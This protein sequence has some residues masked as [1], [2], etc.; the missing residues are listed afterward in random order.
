MSAIS[1]KQLRF[2]I[3]EDSSFFRT[4]IGGMLN[5]LGVSQIDAAQNGNQALEACKS[6]HYHVILCDYD[7][8]KGKTGQ[9]LLE[10]LRH[11]KLIDRQT[12][13]I[14][15]T[16]DTSRQAV[17]ASCEVSADDY[18][19]K[20]INATLLNRRVSRLLIQ[21][22][23]FHTAFEAIEN[24][25]L[26][27]AIDA[28]APLALPSSR[29][30]R[31]ANKL[32]GEVLLKADELDQAKAHYLRALEEKESE[33][34][35]LGLAFV[36]QAR[37]N[38]EAAN[39][40]FRAILINNPFCL[41]ALDG[42]AKSYH[43]QKDWRNL[44]RIVAK[45]VS[46][47]PQSILR[48]KNLAN[49]AEQN[50]DIDTAIN[51]LKACVQLGFNSCYGDW[52]DA[53]RLG[54]NTADAPQ[55]LLDIKDKLPAEALDI[56][57]TAT[58]YFDVP[59]ED[60]LRLQFLQGRLQFL[61]R[62]QLHG[63]QAI[64]KAESLYCE[65]ERM[66]VITDVAR[67]KA[68]R[69]L[70]DDDRAKALTDALKEVYKEDQNALEILDEVLDEPVSKANRKLLAEANKRGIELY[71][72]AEFDE[73]ILCFQ[74]AQVMFPRHVGIQLNICQAYIGKHNRGDGGDLDEVIEQQLAT[75]RRQ[76]DPRDPQYKRYKKLC[77]MIKF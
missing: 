3:V 35:R 75:I 26:P 51:A 2:L 67:I 12:L 36:E 66:D 59:N 22:K 56:L 14:M 15:V 37:G 16:A 9:Q 65:R 72:E 55:A 25:Q 49:I 58:D 39:E 47:S 68:I 44:Q 76:L 17:L 53:Y 74:R 6:H 43:L 42:L 62:Q 10:A 7:L 61:S 33:W 18:I 4:A 50:G 73:A 41:A 28:L 24:D 30:Q 63:K 8:G 54:M 64:E 21:K 19:T 77:E 71:N 11:H 31:L 46:A 5:S 27:E 60:L 29:H 69:T 34:A 1:D 70:E 32:L 20:P 57:K 52:T 23:A 45:G 48:Q 40:A 38:L 13:F